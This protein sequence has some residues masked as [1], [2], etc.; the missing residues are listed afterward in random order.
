MPCRSNQLCRV[1]QDDHAVW[2]VGL[3]IRFMAASDVALQVRKMMTG[4]IVGCQCLSICFHH[5]V[6][7]W[8]IRRKFDGA[9]DLH[10]ST[11]VLDTY[12]PINRPPF[13][14]VGWHRSMHFC[15]HLI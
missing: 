13:H 11:I 7:S 5:I 9:E 6:A 14:T 15:F 4:E 10:G 2:M 8:K 3:K 12:H 1:G